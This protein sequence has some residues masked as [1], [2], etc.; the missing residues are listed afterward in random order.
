[1]A[2]D[3]KLPPRA[4]GDRIEW[5]TVSY[6]TLGL[7][8]GAL[9]LL[10][11]LGWLLLRPDARRRRRR[12]PPQRRDRRPLRARS[13]A[14][15]QVKRAGTLEWMAATLAVVLRQNDLVRTGAGAT[16]EILF[17]DGTHINVRPDSLI[18]IE[19]SSQNPVSRQQRTALA[20]QSGEANFQTA[21]R[22]VPGSTTISTPTVRTTADRDTA[23]N[24]QVAESGE[25]GL[26]IFKGQGE[27][28][29]RAGQQIALG[30]NE[31]GARSTP[32][33]TA[34]PTL[35]LPTV[36]ALTAP[37]NHAEIAYPD[38]AG[39]RHPA[40]VERGAGGLR[41]P[42]DG[43]LQPDLRSPALRPPGPPRRPS[44][45]CAGS[46]PAPTTGRWRPSTRA[47]PRGASPTPGAS[48]S[49]ARRRAPARRRRSPSRPRELKGNIL[50]VRGRTEPGATLTLNG[51]R[52]E[53]Q[54]DGSFNEFVTFEGG[55]GA[56]VV[57]RATTRKGGMVEERRRVTVTQLRRPVARIAVF[58]VRA[59]LAGGASSLRRRLKG[60]PG[61]LEYEFLPAAGAR[62][63]AA[64]DPSRFAAALVPVS[65]ATAAAA[66]RAARRALPG[67]PIGGIAVCSRRRRPPAHRPPR[68]RL[69]GRGV[70]ARGPARPGPCSPTCRE[71]GAGG[72]AARGG[73]RRPRP[74]PGVSR[75]SPT[76]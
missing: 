8:G 11:A 12:P 3:E 14:A 27:A 40:G 46:R 49:R 28:E 33:G 7:V 31:G 73:A 45:R 71:R 65:A 63:H 20:V 67:R 53:V 59:A 5:F 15:S 17:A 47:A 42:R 13:R 64:L 43:G 69:P 68:P 9:V 22:N 37:P 58:S 50:H 34:G 30:A 32:T 36:P 55:A 62:G 39:Q 44:S 41:L 52:L 54:A 72:A 60:V 35:D 6:R 57:L 66:V 56:T 10:G 74:P 19:E 76:S 24:I 70:A 2:S 21:A 25:T 26:R 23:G 38:L 18:T 61:A 29:T 16:A 75:S 4:S 48:R 51:E 1:M